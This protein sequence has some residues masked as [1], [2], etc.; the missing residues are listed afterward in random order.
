MSR[1]LVAKTFNGNWYW[2][3]NKSTMTQSAKTTSFLEGRLGV[4]NGFEFEVK[5]PVKENPNVKYHVHVKEYDIIKVER[6]FIGDD[7]ATHVEEVDSFEF[8]T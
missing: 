6:H 3:E 4:C 7:G 1:V 5:L 8:D 2:S